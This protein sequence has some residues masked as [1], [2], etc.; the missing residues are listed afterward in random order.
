MCF[1]GLA[2][3]DPAQKGRNTIIDEDV[4]L[5]A[6]TLGRGQRQSFK[7]AGLVVGNGLVGGKVVCS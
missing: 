3:F 6:A 4:F 7:R 2:D 5:A 1:W